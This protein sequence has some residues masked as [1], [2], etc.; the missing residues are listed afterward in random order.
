MIKVA[1]KDSRRLNGTPKIKSPKGSTPRFPITTHIN[2]NP[3]NHDRSVVWSSVNFRERMKMT[4]ANRS[5]HNPHTAPFR[6]ADGK[7]RPIDW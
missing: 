2:T 6:G 3:T 7:L 5:D 1:I 4:T